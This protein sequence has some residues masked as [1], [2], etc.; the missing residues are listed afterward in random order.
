MSHLQSGILATPVPAQ[1]RHLF[2]DID[3][4]QA[5]PEALRQLAS[6]AD[7][8]RLLV[9]LG[10]P[11]AYLLERPIPG[12]RGF[13]PVN[14][15]EAKNPATQHALWCWVTGVERSEL[16][17]RSLDLQGI[18]APAFRLVDAADCFRHLSG[19]DLTG[20]EDGTENP[21]DDD[22]IEAAQVASEQPGLQGSS[23][24]AIQQWVHD[25]QGFRQHPQAEQDNMIGRRLSDNHELEDA[26]E[27]AHVKRTAQESF[28]PEAFMVRRSMP[29]IEGLQAGLMFLCFARSLQPF[30]V[31]LQRM[32]GLEDGISDALY[33]FS[34]PITGGYYW[35]PPYN[36]GGL[37][38]QALGL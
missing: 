2:F 18:L 6:L 11:V 15:P 31:Q 10:E 3:Q 38:L 35:C 32:S 9:G 5:V 36:D 27:S 25:L 33:R 14:G 17:E 30:E 4:A 23:F 22:A 7:G 24:A 16:L 34:H 13:A 26:P 19:H 8:Q 37:N 21:Q 28:D 12:L 29:F 1:A 20:Y